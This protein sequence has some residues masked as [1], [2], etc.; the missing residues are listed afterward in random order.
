MCEVSEETCAGVKAP[1]TVEEHEGSGHC[2]VCG[3]LN[4]W[5]QRGV[6]DKGASSEWEPVDYTARYNKDRREMNEKTIH[7]KNSSF[8]AAKSHLHTDFA[9]L[10]LDADAEDP[11]EEFRVNHL[12]KRDDVQVNLGTISSVMKSQ[13]PTCEVAGNKCSQKCRDAL[14]S[15]VLPT[16]LEAT[17]AT[18]HDSREEDKTSMAAVEKCRVAI[19]HASDVACTLY[20]EEDA[21]VEPLVAG[22]RR[23]VVNLHLDGDGDGKLQDEESETVV[24]APA[25]DETEEEEE[26]AEHDVNETRH[27]MPH[28]GAGSQQKKARGEADVEHSDVRE[29]GQ[30]Q[31]SQSESDVSRYFDVYS[32]SP[33]TTL[34]VVLAVAVALVVF[35][36]SFN[37]SDRRA[38]RF[39]GDSTSST[40]L[41]GR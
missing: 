17:T 14:H 28:L 11:V 18:T 33:Y 4:H 31:G 39:S 21:C 23:S 35:N 24:S 34:I 38:E 15:T 37:R 29:E 5:V 32:T 7:L 26:K 20:G 13:F 10:G 22:F 40:G 30:S 19:A 3:L 8:E 2:Q 36:K 16:C 12:M 1:T 25:T 41:L 9:H 27:I 6:K